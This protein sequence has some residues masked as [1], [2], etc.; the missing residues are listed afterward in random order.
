[1]LNPI[2][3]LSIAILWFKKVTSLPKPQSRGVQQAARAPQPARQAI[4]CGP[5]QLSK[6]LKSISFIITL[7]NLIKSS[8]V[9]L[10]R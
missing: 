3:L 1:M 7:T 8:I 5:R 10:A 4:Q 6:L 9:L 2:W